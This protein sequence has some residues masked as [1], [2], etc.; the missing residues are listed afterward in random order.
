LYLGELNEGDISP[1]EAE[2]AAKH[3]VQVEFTLHP[4]Y[5]RLTLWCA[6]M[7][8]QTRIV[9]DENEVEISLHLEHSAR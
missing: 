2:E 8:A 9:Q 3:P 6:V 1:S 5:M 7:F 4:N